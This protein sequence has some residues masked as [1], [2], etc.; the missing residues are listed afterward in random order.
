VMVCH[1]VVA[2]LDVVISDLRRDKVIDEMLPWFVRG[3]V[4]GQWGGR[5]RSMASD[6]TLARQIKQEK[7]KQT[8]K[9][10]ETRVWVT[11]TL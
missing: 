1:Q 3:V 5:G 6:A 11:Y 9:V 4:S 10:N 8:R 7:L 2:T